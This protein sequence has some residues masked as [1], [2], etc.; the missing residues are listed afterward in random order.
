MDSYIV[1]NVSTVKSFNFDFYI[2]STRVCQSL[3][4]CQCAFIQYASTCNYVH[5]INKYFWLPSTFGLLY[6]YI[7]I[8][9]CCNKCCS[10]RTIAMKN[11]GVLFNL[12]DC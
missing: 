3:L 4:I 1:T 7:T 2:I 11:A 8:W 10:S 5:F 12:I 9:T 6:I